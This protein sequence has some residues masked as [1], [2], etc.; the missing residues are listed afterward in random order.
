MQT[1]HAVKQQAQDWAVIE[2]ATK[3]VVDIFDSEA[4]AFEG[5]WLLVE[6]DRIMNQYVPKKYAVLDP[7]GNVL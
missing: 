3:E 6:Y 2:R 5:K 1:D 4:E 7:H